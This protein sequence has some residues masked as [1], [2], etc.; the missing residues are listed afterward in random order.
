MNQSIGANTRNVALVG[1]YSSGKTSLLESLLFVTGA[2]TRKGKISDRNTVGD[3]STQAR[4]RQMSVEVSVAHSQY[5]DLNFTFL[6][7]PGS[8]EFASE[9]YNALVGAGAAIIVCEPVVDRVLTLAPLLKF[10]DDWEIPHLIFINKMDRCNSHFNEVL[11]ALKSV[12]S[13]PLVPQQYPIRQNNEI[14]GFIDLI[15][16]QAYHYHANSPADPVALPDHLKEEEQIARQEMLETIA[17][18]DDHLLE[19]L[20]EDINPSREEILQDLKQELGADQIV[21]VFFGMA[22]RDYG[23][24]HLLTALVEEAPAPTIT[25]NRRGLDPSADGDAVVQILKTYFTPQGG[26]LSLGRIWQGTLSDGMALNG[27]R[28]GGIY[29]LMGQ[30]QQPLQQAQAGEIVA[31][32]RLEGIATGDV[33]SSGSQKPDLPQGLQLKPVFAL[34][35]AAANRKDEVKLSSALTKLIEEDP[36]LHWEQHGDTKEVILWGQG[37][38]HLQVALDRLARKY[39]LPMTTHLPQVPYKETIKTSTKSHGRYKH[40]TGG[41]GAFG[42]VYLDIKPLPRGE[43]FHFHETIVGGVVP[44][45][46]I[47]GVETGV[48]EYLGHGPLGFPVVDIDV[49]LTDGSYHS[50][51]SSEQAFKQAARLAM[52]EGLPKCHPVLLEPI[53]SVTVLAPSEYTAKVLQL[54]SGKRGQIQGFE[55]SEEWKGWDQVTAHLPQAEMHDFIVEL[56]SL[57]MGVGFFQWD[58]DHLQEVPDKLR[59][60]VLA[61]QGNGNK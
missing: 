31:L 56:R 39:N 7:C 42:D 49:T 8:I 34:A 40:Q 28:I 26:R 27:V 18:F 24:R 21:P 30:Q 41:H 13:R 51:D 9:T 16:E 47:P 4:D 61:M 15:N 12:S 35:I 58:E 5:Q 48:R 29:R 36:S 46:Y 2:I 53:L 23:V 22:E 17:E 11:Q 57:T 50:V 59:D 38:I 19:E 37:E 52:T 44:K 43:G 45:Q 55:A 33:V 10:L 14:I 3:S 60:A 32:G 20:L 6:D 54:I 25:A 1:P